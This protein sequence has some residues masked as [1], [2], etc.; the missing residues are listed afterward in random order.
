MMN[1]F[2][3]LLVGVD[4]IVIFICMLLFYVYNV[5]KWLMWFFGSVGCRILLFLVYMLVMVLVLSL[6][7]I[8]YD[9]FVLVFFLM[10]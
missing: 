10:K 3:V 2:I 1:F 4:F 7:V 6:L 9:C 8:L 5:I